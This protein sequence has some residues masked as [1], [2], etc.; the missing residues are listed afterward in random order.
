MLSNKKHYDRLNEKNI[1]IEEVFLKNSDN[2]ELIRAS[3]S[4]RSDSIFGLPLFQKRY[5]FNNNCIYV[6][7]QFDKYTTYT[8]LDH[9]QKHNLECP[10]CGFQGYINLFY[11]GCPYCGTNFNIDYKIKKEQLNNFVKSKYGYLIPIILIILLGILSFL[12]L[13]TSKLEL[14]YWIICFISSFPIVLIP[15]TIFIVFISKSKPTDTNISPHLKKEYNNI[16]SNLNFELKNYYYN[17]E[18]YNELIDFNIFKYYSVLDL[19]NNYIEIE[20]DIGLVYFNS[21]NDIKKNNKHLK[22][23]MRKNNNKIE[24]NFII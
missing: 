12:W 20:F 1:V 24:K 3:D 13:Y 23:V 4:L 2:S 7:D 22:V 16:I 5:F 14:K 9:S 15:W 17:E 19:N 11:E 21:H 10:N 8:Y 6:E 18:Q